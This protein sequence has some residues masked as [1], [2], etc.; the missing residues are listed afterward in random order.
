MTD[1]FDS[2]IEISDLIR[3]VH[4]DLVDSENKRVEEGI[5]PL[6]QLILQRHFNL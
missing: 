4:K 6:M 2:E 5:Q 1:F 3:K